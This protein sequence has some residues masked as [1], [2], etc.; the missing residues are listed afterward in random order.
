[1]NLAQLNMRHVQPITCNWTVIYRNLELLCHHLIM[2]HT[3]IWPD[4]L[5]PDIRTPECLRHSSTNAVSQDGLLKL[6]WSSPQ[7][8]AYRYRSW[9]YRN[10]M[11]V[12]ILPLQ[13]KS[14]TILCLIIQHKVDAFPCTTCYLLTLRI[15]MPYSFTYRSCIKRWSN[16]TVLVLP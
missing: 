10:R 6:C 13:C 9:Y 11:I 8:W 7:K 3:F 5:W 2:R 16:V 15:Y 12:L 14:L 1:M 4:A